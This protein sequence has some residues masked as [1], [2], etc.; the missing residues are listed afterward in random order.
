M[1]QS[2]VALTSASPAH[3]P[4]AMPTLVVLQGSGFAKG[5]P[6][7]W[8]LRCR[9]T[10]ACPTAGP[11]CTT[12]THEGYGG[13][14]IYTNATVLNDT[15]ATCIAPAV[16]APGPGLLSVCLNQGVWVCNGP[17]NEVRISYF[18][19]VDAV[20][21]RRPYLNESRG[22]LLVTA[23]TSLAGKTLA[24]TASVGFDTS[25][26]WTWRFAPNVNHLTAVLPMELSNLPATINADLRVDVRW[27]AQSGYNLTI[28][29]RLMRTPLPADKKA[30]AAAVQVDHSTRALRVGGQAWQGSGWFVS[31]PSWPPVHWLPCTRP[32]INRTVCSS[33]WLETIRPRASL[34]T[35]TQ[36]MPYGLWKLEPDAQLAFLDACEI[37][38]VKVMY[39]MVQLGMSALGGMN[40]D[41]D[42]ASAAWRMHVTANVS[43]VRNHS[44]VLGYYVCDVSY[45]FNL[46]CRI[47][48]QLINCTI[49]S[50]RRT[51]ARSIR[52][53]AMCPSRQNCTTSSSH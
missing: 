34:G 25:K 30:A 23:H 42:W 17:S 3:F 36:I 48:L 9:L 45:H 27:G 22:A 28:F 8:H 52:T 11:R 47:M 16:F 10:N 31:M 19:L 14:A 38:G 32:P 49:L 1:A 39:P 51:V 29:R 24:L 50:G 44:A 37:L 53:W 15:H 41:T 33:L 40:Y 5:A 4:T 20:L 12:F 6:S 2:P 7:S 46:F 35:L 13:G 21:S 43:L 26:N 18:T